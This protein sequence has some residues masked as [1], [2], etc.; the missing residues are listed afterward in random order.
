[1][2]DFF[3]FFNDLPGATKIS[4]M[5]DNRSRM[6]PTNALLSPVETPDRGYSRKEL[7]D[8]MKNRPDE[9][10]VYIPASGLDDSAYHGSELLGNG[11][12][13]AFDMHKYTNLDDDL[14]IS[15]SEFPT[16]YEHN[17][18]MDVWRRG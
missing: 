17:M 6:E 13:D 2:S 3:R 18:N 11:F 10:E 8:L 9:G 1:M 5:V 15:D 16:G 4:R 14:D 7:A 12:L